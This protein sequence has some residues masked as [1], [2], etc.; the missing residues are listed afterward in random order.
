MLVYL[1]A[2]V[3]RMSVDVSNNSNNSNIYI[4]IHIWDLYGIHICAYIYQCAGYT[5]IYNYI[6]IY[7]YMVH[8]S[9][10]MKRDCMYVQYM[11]SMCYSS[12][13]W[14]DEWF[15]TNNLDLPKEPPPKKT[16]DFP[17]SGFPIEKIKHHLQQI[18]PYQWSRLAG[19][20]GARS[21]SYWCLSCGGIDTVLN[22]LEIRSISYGGCPKYLFPDSP[23]SLSQSRS[24]RGTTVSNRGRVCSSLIRSFT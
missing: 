7:Y 12:N 11:Y 14:P 18:Q 9:I 10:N 8:H 23:Q 20:N 19:R 21:L 22:R 3:R 2:N 16:K 4:Y 15:K 13:S 17:S 1:C 5:C 6:Y 24:N